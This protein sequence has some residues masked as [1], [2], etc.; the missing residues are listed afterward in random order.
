MEN[1][2]RY[3]VDNP[4]MALLVI[5][6]AGIVFFFL[7]KKILKYALISL[8]VFMVLAGYSYYKAPEEFPERFKSNLSEIRDRSGDVVE[9]GR[10][11]AET[12]DK[13]VEKGR[14]LFSDR[15]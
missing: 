1:M 6:S 10:D 11:I 13:M 7:L 15:E 12:V 9:K 14:D 3:L 4:L 8:A 2:L 5:L